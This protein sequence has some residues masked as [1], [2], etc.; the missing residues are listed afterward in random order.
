MTRWERQ[1]AV[2]SALLERAWSA[3]SGMDAWNSRVAT[4]AFLL[5][6]ETGIRTQELVRVRAKDL[7]LALGLLVVAYPKPV[8]RHGRVIRVLAVS[9]AATT[10]ARPMV[11]G[12]FGNGDETMPVLCR[13]G[14]EGLTWLSPKQLE[15]L[16]GEMSGQ[17]LPPDLSLREMRRDYATWMRRPADQR[18][19]K[20]GTP[21]ARNRARSALMGHHEFGGQS[22]FV[23]DRPLDC[24]D[25]AFVPDLNPPPSPVLDP[26]GFEHPWQPPP[27]KQRP[28]GPQWVTQGV[29]PEYVGLDRRD[30]VHASLMEMRWPD[31]MG[32]E[33]DEAL[34]TALLLRL[35]GFGDLLVQEPL[36]ALESLTWDDVTD[37]GDGLILK[38]PGAGGLEVWAGSEEQFLFGILRDRGLERPFV[39][40]SQDTADRAVAALVGPGATLEAL[41][42]SNLLTHLQTHTNEEIG[43]LSAR[44]SRWT[45]GE[46]KSQGSR[47]YRLAYGIWK[48]FHNCLRKMGKERLDEGKMRRLIDAHVPGWEQTAED[49][50]K[51]HALLAAART[52]RPPG[53]RRGTMSA[54]TAKNVLEDVLRILGHA[55]IEHLARFGLEDLVDAN[56][57]RRGG[58]DRTRDAWSAIRGAARSLEIPLPRFPLPRDEVSFRGRRIPPISKFAEAV[59]TL[60]PEEQ[61]VAALLITIL[62][63]VRDSEIKILDSS[64]LR[65]IPAACGG[66]G[67]ARILVQIDKQKGGGPGR[68]QIHVAPWAAPWVEDW[69]AILGSLRP[70]QQLLDAWP[71]AGNPL[72]PGGPLRSAFAT[73]GEAWSSHLCRNIAAMEMTDAGVDRALIGLRLGHGALSSSASYVVLDPGRIGSRREPAGKAGGSQL[74]AHAI[75]YCLGLSVSQISRRRAKTGGDLRSSPRPCRNSSH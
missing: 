61:A 19:P 36:T 18:P 37:T 4:L 70:D 58:W 21:Q 63:A 34:T 28:L 75:A 55:S 72:R 12:L 54:N 46:R 43:Y 17:P 32:L 52:S 9:E 74:S 50:L 51:G 15:E 41:R 56:G 11:D 71:G 25:E 67:E 6:L 49:L 31:E 26:P 45:V 1:H 65:L 35:V 13:W 10:I 53:A 38:I 47:P 2:L 8:A 44:T 59:A 57:G 66:G 33:K 62:T 24:G 60:P 30:A 64:D 68:R 39:A 69:V 27:A 16:I 5:A 3:A 20:P 73:I 22:V 7:S 23:P 42:Q 14:P 29:S 48:R 40:C